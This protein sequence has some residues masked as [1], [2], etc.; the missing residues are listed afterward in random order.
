MGSFATWNIGVSRWASWRSGIGDIDSLNL[1]IEGTLD[2]AD[3]NERA[4]AL[5]FWP[6]DSK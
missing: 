6:L 5:F 4:T 1:I 2:V 3:I